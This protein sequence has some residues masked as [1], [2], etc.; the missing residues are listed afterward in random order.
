MCDDAQWATESIFLSFLRPF[1]HF[2][3]L[4]RSFTSLF[5]WLFFPNSYHLFLNYSTPRNRDDR[6]KWLKVFSILLSLRESRPG[7]PSRISPWLTYFTTRTV[8]ESTKH[9][10]MFLSPL[11]NPRASRKKETIKWSKEICPRLTEHGIIRESQELSRASSNFHTKY[12]IQILKPRWSGARR[13][14]IRP[15]IRVTVFIMWLMQIYC[16]CFICFV[17]LYFFF[18]FLIY[19]DIRDERKF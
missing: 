13:I 17:F 15:R 7:D 19:C 4:I 14:F 2:N 1:V 16:L 10:T 12:F 11:Q 3:S 8:A 9:D 18:F 5:I 6:K